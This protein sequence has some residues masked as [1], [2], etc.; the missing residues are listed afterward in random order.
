LDVYI[1]I[2]LTGRAD[3]LEGQRFLSR[4]EDSDVVRTAQSIIRNKFHAVEQSGWRR[5]LESSAFY[6]DLDRREKEAKLDEARRRLIR[7]LR[8]L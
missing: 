7:W 4:H 6:P 1:T 8:A 3:Y 5:V 2:R